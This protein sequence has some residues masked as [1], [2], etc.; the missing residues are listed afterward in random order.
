VTSWSFFE[1]LE[2]VYCTALRYPPLPQHHFAIF[3]HF[4]IELKNNKQIYNFSESSKSR[5]QRFEEPHTALEPQFGHPCYMHWPG[6]SRSCLVAYPFFNGNHVFLHFLAAVIGQSQ[7]GTLGLSTADQIHGQRYK[8]LWR[9]TG[10]HE[11]HW[12]HGRIEPVS[13]GGG[14]FQ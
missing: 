6:E 11:Q 2:K 5:I 13:S 4:A 1:R 14:R 10:W 8:T 12:N 7:N 3:L 9:L